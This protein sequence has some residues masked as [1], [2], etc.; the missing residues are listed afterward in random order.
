MELDNTTI[1]LL[2]ALAILLYG[3]NN[4]RKKVSKKEDFRYVSL[5]CN[6][7]GDYYKMHGIPYDPFMI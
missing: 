1:V 4:C 3:Y 7:Y 2:I 6:P 5:R